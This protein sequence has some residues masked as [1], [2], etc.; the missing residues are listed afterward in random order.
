MIPLWMTDD[1]AGAVLVRMGVQV[2]RPAVGRPARVRET[3]G[4]VWGP[5]GQGRLEV[6]QLAGS[7]LHEEVAGV[8]DERDAG[9]IVAAIFEALEA[10]DEDGS[11]LPGTRVPDDAAHRCHASAR[12]RRQPPTGRGDS[13]GWA[14][15]LV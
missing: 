5:I 12:A 13:A 8:I 6:G 2:V 1:V 11:R 15:A 3:D 9:R 14:P 7:L 10:L 4:G